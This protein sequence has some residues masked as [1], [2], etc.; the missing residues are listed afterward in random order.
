MAGA[1][2]ALQEDNDWLRK[3]LR[4]NAA[5]VQNPTQELASWWAT[6][7]VAMVEEA[8]KTLE[9]NL[10]LR[11]DIQRQID[12]LLADLSRIPAE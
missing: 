7:Q 10:Q 3:L 12:K 4:E 6:E 5:R 1:A 2:T 8:R 11:A 9:R